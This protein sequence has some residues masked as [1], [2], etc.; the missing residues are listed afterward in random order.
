MKGLEFIS[1]SGKFT[2]CNF[3]TVLQLPMEQ[4]KILDWKKNLLELVV[5]VG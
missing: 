5:V 1:C 3:E 4:I 2:I